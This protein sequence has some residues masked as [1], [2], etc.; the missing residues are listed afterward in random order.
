MAYHCRIVVIAALASPKVAMRPCRMRT[1]RWCSF[2]SLSGY[3]T[4]AQV[5][6]QPEGAL[7][8]LGHPIIQAVLRERAEIALL[9]FVAAY[10]AARSDPVKVEATLDCALNHIECFTCTSAVSQTELQPVELAF[11]AYLQD[12]LRHGAAGEQATLA[13][14]LAK[15]A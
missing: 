12:A 10:R 3:C 1:W 9:V 15:M 5:H 13:H 8:A 7:S 11:E 6:R 14:A 2:Q 4:S